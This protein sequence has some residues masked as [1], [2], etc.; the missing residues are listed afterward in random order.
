VLAIDDFDVQPELHEPDTIP[1]EFIIVE[2]VGTF[3]ET[4]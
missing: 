1:N 4:L 2:N 3:I